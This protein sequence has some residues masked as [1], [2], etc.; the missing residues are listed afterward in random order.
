MEKNRLLDPTTL[1][2]S[3]F[4]LL[5]NITV[6]L[7]QDQSSSQQTDKSIAEERTG[8]HFMLYG[9]LISIWNP[10]GIGFYGG[11]N[12]H[13]VYRYDNNIGAENP[14]WQTGLGLGLSP[15]YG[16][17]NVHFEWMPWIILPLRVQYDYYHY[18][19]VNQGLLSFNSA[20]ASFSESVIKNRHDEEVANGQR[21]MF[22]PTLQGKI[23]PILLQNQ[24]DFA[25]YNFSGRGPFFLELDN[26]TLLKNNDW[27]ITN[28]TQLM[29]ESWKGLHEE[30][31]LVG[32]YYEAGRAVDASITQQKIGGQFYWVPLE[33]IWGLDRPRVVMRVGYYLQDPNLKGQI[34]FLMGLGFD[35]DIGS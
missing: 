5:V 29:Y 1:I 24:T 19:G 11:I 6:T 13:D 10:L 31:L 9:D 15:A 28:I 23:G 8:G 16:N 4:I 35:L 33:S 25:H 30:T 22:Q 26:Y 3:L 14:Y 32:P 34:Y 27:L 7:A 20:N 18:F 21:F 2:L 17:A 12:Y